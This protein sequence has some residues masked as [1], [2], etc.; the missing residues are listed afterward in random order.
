MTHLELATARPSAINV[1][2]ILCYVGYHDGL[3]FVSFV[4]V[5]PS[6]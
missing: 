1:I 2:C 5:F 6:G 3:N 4:G